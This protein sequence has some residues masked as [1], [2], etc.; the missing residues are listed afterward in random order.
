MIPVFDGHNDL[1]LR[2]WSKTEGDPLRD[3]VDGD[4]SAFLEVAARSR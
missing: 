3:F 4:G 2:L 1:L